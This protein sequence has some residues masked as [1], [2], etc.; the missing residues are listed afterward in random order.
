MLDVVIP[1]I[2]GREESLYKL[3]DS[4]VVDNQE[5]G[6]NLIVVNDEG[7]LA[8]KRNKGARQGKGDLILFIDDDDYCEK[9]SLSRI[10]KVFKRPTVG[11]CGMVACYH[12]NKGKIAD[13]GSLRSMM[14]GF[15]L[16]VD[17]NK[18]LWWKG[19][20]TVD[21]V[22][23][24][25]VV[26]RSLF[27]KLG[28]FDEENFPIELDEADLCRRV[29]NSGFEIV[30][31]A[32]AVVYHNSQ[33]YSYFPNFRK[34]QSAYYMGRNRIIYQKKHGSCYFLYHL[35][36]LPIFV[37]FYTITL[38]LRKKPQMVVAFLKGVR[39]G[40]RKEVTRYRR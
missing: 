11:I 8:Y 5:V 1:T 22:A 30:M 27:E 38:S 21:E 31:C 24:A 36:F 28:G 3:I 9:S 33:T 37:L 35:L 23:N 7:L 32:D 12:N 25:F 17:T 18:S 39:D 16:G 13:G 4:I 19:T 15:T 26:R 40:I 29:K 20:Y 2:K 34:E 14:T 6:A 10:I